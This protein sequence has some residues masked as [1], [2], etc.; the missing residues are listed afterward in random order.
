MLCVIEAKYLDGFRIMVKFNDL[1]EGVI[2]LESVI[3]NDHRRIFTELTDKD[4]FKKFN[5]DMD[6]IVWENGLD[7]APEFLYERIS[8]C[9]FKPIR[10][11]TEK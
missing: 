1:H 5:V 4:N 10:S 9:E 6:T 11:Q 7:L 2:D 8:E 3:R